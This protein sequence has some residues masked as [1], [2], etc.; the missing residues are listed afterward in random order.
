M[1]AG[2]D[3]GE[4]TRGWGIFKTRHALRSRSASS[5]SLLLDNKAQDGVP[6]LVCVCVSV[7]VCVCVCVCSPGCHH[8]HHHATLILSWFGRQI[9]L[10]A[11]QRGHPTPIRKGASILY[12]LNQT[13]LSPSLPRPCTALVTTLLLVLN[14]FPSYR[15]LLSSSCLPSAAL[16]S[17]PEP[18]PSPAPGFLVA[19]PRSLTGVGFRSLVPFG[20][21]CAATGEREREW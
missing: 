5:R 9:Q 10:G 20:P 11:I 6:L 7:C 12:P 8:H 13:P 15:R 14:Q 3:E 16:C 1:R 19:E 21:C 18:L 17:P 2:I 4:E